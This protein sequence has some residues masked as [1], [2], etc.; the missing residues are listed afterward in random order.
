MSSILL[1][2]PASVYIAALVA[3]D[4][5]IPEARRNR[6]ADVMLSRDKTIARTLT[7]ALAFCVTLGLSISRATAEAQILVDVETGKVLHAENATVPWYPASITKIMTT[8]ATLRAVK[9]GRI[10]L[11][12]L[13]TVSPNALAQSPVKMGFPVGTT[14]TVD[15]ALKI[16]L[17]KSAND[18][19][20]VLAEGVGGSI[21][22][23]AD[24]MNRHAQRLGMTQSHFVNPNGLPAD[25]QVT[26]AR[27]MAILA[28]AAIKEFPEYDYYWHLPGIRFGKKVLRNYNSLIGRYPGADGMKTGFICA[29][30]FNLVATAT[31]DGKRLIAVVLG[32]PSSSGRALHAAALLE[33]GFAPDKLG[34]LT[35]EIG[36]VESLTPVNAEPPNLREDMCGKHRKKQASE[37]EDDSAAIASLL[38]SSGSAYSVFLSALRAPAGNKQAVLQ[39]EARLGEPVPV[40]L[41]PAKKLAIAAEPKGG[42]TKS[43]IA[44]TAVGG[45]EL[46]SRS[47]GGSS[48]PLPRPRPKIVRTTAAP[49]TGASAT[50]PQTTAA[51]APPRP[52][53]AKPDTKTDAKKK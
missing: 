45:P 53:A 25:E 17:V 26:S 29:S 40:H 12:K 8:Y 46:A 52:A 27:D 16:L 39:Q 32:A 36:T 6:I 42:K 3:L 20:V 38:S 35:A 28:R 31:R 44:A 13:L 50:T 19:A 4:R 9:E 49:S 23:F 22:N 5:V 14:I 51:H 48:V 11:D 1:L 41:G 33:R 30:G 34:W 10:T 37:D 18:M 43:A 7:C 21:E 15:N 2:P 47:D 24:M